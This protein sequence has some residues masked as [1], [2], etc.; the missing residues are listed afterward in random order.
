MKLNTRQFGEIEVDDATIITFKSGLP[1]FQDL[2]R[3]TII[4]MDD[5][6]DGTFCWLQSVDNGDVTFVL[7]DVFEVIEGYNPLVETE[8]L[9]ELGEFDEN[10]LLV[11]NIVNVRDNVKNMTVN[12][13]APIVINTKTLLGCQIIVNNEEYS[14][15][16]RV[17][18]EPAIED[19]KAGEA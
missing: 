15:K 8:H 4:K 2:K 9:A 6:N 7:M 17:F 16:H 1:G 10:N 18:P 19:E 12:L 11:L 3:F 13:K 5:N 14:V